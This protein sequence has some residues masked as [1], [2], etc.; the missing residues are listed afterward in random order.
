MRRKHWNLFRHCPSLSPCA[1]PS[2]RKVGITVSFLPAVRCHA[3]KALPW[4]W[5]SGISTK[6][7]WIVSTANQFLAAMQANHRQQIAWPNLSHIYCQCLLHCSGEIC[8]YSPATYTPAGKFPSTAGHWWKLNSSI[9]FLKLKLDLASRWSLSSVLTCFQL[10]VLWNHQ[11]TFSHGASAVTLTAQAPPSVTAGSW[12]PF[13]RRT[14]LGQCT[15]MLRHKFATTSH[16]S[17]LHTHAYL[18]FKL[19]VLQVYMHEPIMWKLSD[20]RGIDPETF[21]SESA[22]WLPACTTAYLPTVPISSGQ[23][24]FGDRN[25]TSRPTTQKNRFVPICPDQ[26]PKTR[27]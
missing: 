17:Y 16:I 11:C 5:V 14:C 20:R 7:S 2:T 18:L 15:L 6:T 10:S 13:V 25:P 24:R 22:A 19:F 26:R 3:R 21:R 23:S 1:A 27:F 9:T 8:R 4:F 12:A